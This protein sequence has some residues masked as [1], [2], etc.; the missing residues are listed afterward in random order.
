MPFKFTLKQ[1]RTFRSCK[2]AAFSVAI[3]K[4][5]KLKLLCRDRHSNAGHRTRQS[6][7]TTGPVNCNITSI[8]HYVKHNERRNGTMSRLCNG[9]WP[10][11]CSS[12]LDYRREERASVSERRGRGPH[13]CTTPF[14]TCTSNLQFDL[15]EGPC[16]FSFPS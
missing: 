6:D 12:K 15:F 7:A 3:G 16:G 14:Q 8:R 9:P 1:I 4:T 11:H 10:W 2:H 5:T 13:L